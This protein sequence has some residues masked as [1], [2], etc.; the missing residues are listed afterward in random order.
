M[1]YLRKGI[2]LSE[3]KE[4]LKSN[5]NDKEY[6]TQFLIDFTRNSYIVCAIILY[7]IVK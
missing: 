3:E 4:T 1:C 2:I 6:L 5:E 7:E